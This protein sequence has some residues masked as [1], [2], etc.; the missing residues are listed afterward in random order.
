[1]LNERDA[2][3]MNAGTPW[4]R[5]A[6][7]LSSVQRQQEQRECGTTLHS[8]TKQESDWNALRLEVSL[9][10]RETVKW[11]VLKILPSLVVFG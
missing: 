9:R 7:N 6:G 2:S 3:K 10:T 11:W 4:I 1:M 8:V 5:D